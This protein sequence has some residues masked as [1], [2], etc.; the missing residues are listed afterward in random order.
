M[1]AAVVA[2]VLLAGCAWPSVPSTTH[3]ET[4]RAESDVSD[5]TPSYSTQHAC[6]AT[7]LPKRLS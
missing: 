2:A 5:G 7:T 3:N 1:S 4:L 6:S